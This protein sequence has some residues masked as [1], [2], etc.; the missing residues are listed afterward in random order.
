MNNMAKM[1][2]TKMAEF[3]AELNQASS[4]SR[5]NPNTIAG[6]NSEFLAFK[7]F[8]CNSLALLRTEMDALRSGIDRIE[9]RFRSRMLLV[10]GIPELPGEDTCSTLVATLSP[11]CKLQNLSV[12]SIAASYRM[13]KLAPGNSKPRPIV[14]KFSDAAARAALWRG[15]TALKGSKITIS[16]FLTKTRHE[17]FMAARAKYGV[18]NCWTAEGVIFIKTPDGNRRRLESMA[19]FLIIAAGNSSN[20]S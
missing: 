7:T 11:R 2:E 6:L 10:H 8:V 4:S 16:E 18:S 14:V 19:E 20:K 5:K 3:Q 17:V 9:M 15:K 13:G 12:S 1:F